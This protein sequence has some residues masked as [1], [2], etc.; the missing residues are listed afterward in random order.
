MVK[1]FE[2]NLK[3]VEDAWL[4]VSMSTSA[5]TASQKFFLRE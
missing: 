2:I 5:D 3:L 1:Q 4:S